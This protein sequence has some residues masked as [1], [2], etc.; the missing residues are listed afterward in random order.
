MRI[1][2]NFGNEEAEII[3]DSYKFE[4]PEEFKNAVVTV[5]SKMIIP[6]DVEVDV[7]CGN[8]FGGKNEEEEEG[9]AG[10]AQE[11]QKVNDIIDGFKYEHYNMDKDGFKEY[12]REYLKFV[13][14]KVPENRVADFKAGAQAF[15]KFV[16]ANFKD[17]VIYTPSDN[18]YEG[19]LI[20]ERY[21]N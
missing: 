14:P 13:L 19:A 15:V 4:Y 21:V 3:S 17:F 18:N 1:Y 9:G 2:H 6:K 10:N 20:Y 7:G 5:Q 16:L 8:A 11:V 12:I